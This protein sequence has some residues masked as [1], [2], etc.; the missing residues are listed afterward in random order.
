MM[1]AK[2]Q[3]LRVPDT[4]NGLETWRRWAATALL[5][6]ASVAHL[7]AFPTTARAVQTLTAVAHWSL[8]VHE[9]LREL[10]SGDLDGDGQGEV[11]AVGRN[12]YLAALEADGKVIWETQLSEETYSACLADLD[13]DEAA[14]VLI[15]GPRGV[16]ALRGDGETLWFYRTGNPVD[17][18]AAADVQNDGHMEVLAATGYE[19]VYELSS[20]GQIIWHYWPQRR[21][22]G[23]T[24]RG[25]AIA[26]YDEDGRK[27]VAIAFD[28]PGYKDLPPSGHI[29]L[30][31]HD[32]KELWLR[33]L[34]TAALSIS[35]IDPDGWGRY[36]IAVG[37]EAGEF[38]TLYGDNSMRWYHELGSPVIC[39]IT[40]DLD[41]DQ[42]EEVVAVA[43]H[44]LLAL[45]DDGSLRWERDTSQQCVDAALGGSEGSV[46]RP[47]AVLSQISGQRKSAVELI[48]VRGGIEESYILPSLATHVH[49]SDLNAD[50]WAELLVQAGESVQLL[51]RA[52][53]V[54]HSRLSWRFKLD[55]EVTALDCS[56]VDADGRMEILAGAQDQNLYVLKDDASLAW[57]YTAPGVIRTV[58]TG[59]VDADG[60]REVIVGYNKFDQR[61][62]QQ[63]W[64]LS[65]LRGDGRVLWQYQMDNWLWSV[66][67]ADLNGDGKDEVLVGTGSNRVLAI[68]G[69]HLLWSYPTYGS[70]VSLFAADLN[71]GGRAEVLAGSEDHRAYDILGNGIL[72]WSWNTGRNVPVVCAADLNSDSLS[73]VLI[74]SEQGVLYALRLDGVT[75]WQNDLHDTPLALYAGD[76]DNDRRMEIA[77]GTRGGE[78]YMLGGTGSTLWEYALQARLLSVY[79]GDVDGDRHAEIV[80]GSVDGVLYV[81]TAGGKLE[82]RHELG[83]AV[84]MLWVGDLDA[85]GL[86][87]ILAGTRDGQVVMYEHTPNRPPLIS[88]PSIGPAEAGYIYAVDVSDPEGDKVDV[89]L[90]VQDPFSGNWHSVGTKTAT[91]SGMLYWFVDPFPILA[92][93]RMAA[94]RLT[95]SD[96]LNTGTLGP[97]RG[98]RVPGIPWYAYAAVPLV[99]SVFAGSYLTWRRSPTRR[100]RALYQ[101]L[102]KDPQQ[103]MAAMSP[104][105][106]NGNAT[107]ETLIRLAQQAR[108]AGD[109]T[110][111]GLAE[112][113]LLLSNRPTM[114]LQV[115]AAA[116]SHGSEAETQ[117]SDAR[118]VLVQI[119]KLLADLLEANS[120]ARIAV[121][122]PKL[123]RVQ[124]LVRAYEQVESEALL[125]L[126]DVRPALGQL[127]H[128]TKLMRNSERAEAAEDKLD[129]LTQAFEALG[130][131]AALRGGPQADVLSLIAQSWQRVITTL[132]EEWLG[133]AQLRCRLR[134][135]RIVA[136]REAVLMLE[137]QNKG[138]SPAVQTSVELGHA[139]NYQD[140]SG[141]VTLG[142]LM[143]G[144]MREASLRLMPP[145]EDQFRAEFVLR[146]D[147][148]E[149]QGKSQVF[150]DMVEVLAPSE[151]RIIPNP[152]VPGRPLEPASPMFYG[153]EEVFDFIAQNARGLL[154]RNILILIGQR[155]TG[156]TSMLLQLPFHLDDQYVVVYL[157]CQSLGLTPGLPSW[158]YDVATIIGET[159]VERGVHVATPTLEALE[160]QPARVFERDYLAQVQDALGDRT[161]L[162]LMDEF[163][164]L[165]M[166]VRAGRLDPTVFSYLRHLMQHTQRV[167]FAFVGTHRL[168]EMTT[169]YWSVL[170]N[171]ALYRH[172][173]YLDENSA[174]RLIIEPVQPYNM[175]YDDLAL[176]R[177]WQVTGGHPYFLQLL[178]YSLV[179]AHNRA[180]R[181]YTTVDDVDQALE[182]ILTL[183]SAHFSFLWETS[184]AR[185]RATLAVLTRLLSRLGQ[186]TWP[187][188]GATASDVAVLLA[189]HNLTLD[190]REVS[191]ALHSL[192]AR[193][194]LQEIPGDV[195]RYVFKVG[196]VA[197][198][199]E[200][201]KSL[202]SVIEELS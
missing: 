115:V 49:L 46:G 65:V 130:P 116:L 131:L 178:C 190:P 98:P 24:V 9:S 133:R 67:V 6:L 137:V 17:A 183:G 197:L 85:D 10:L 74:A 64:G 166:R 59:D 55:A 8:P 123:Q 76:W 37:T 80:A 120:V 145:N 13:N 151:F 165:E 161:L 92:A 35:A 83:D 90:E 174:R 113:Y 117:D 14:D 162:L 101:C 28:F 62:D 4:S 18:V 109:Q 11:V 125:P 148:R 52:R 19:H 84:S 149:A 146:Y 150:A 158:L 54:A 86:A 77:T 27:E 180:G 53:G 102:S 30:L 57:R 179:N 103:V 16:T 153:R 81:V 31:D 195:E 127:L 93:S 196:L 167:A 66:Q 23:G 91:R 88:N 189:E 201:F 71:G 75:F 105:A 141:G 136:G 202:Q 194:I 22:F 191:A 95:Y 186:A 119:Y 96:G 39:V 159:L 56:D 51:S 7:L 177:M 43:E 32:G 176:H 200:R 48:D 122:S 169:D 21:G 171:I 73:E 143:P 72:R 38:M 47:V 155:R 170:F 61:G 114:G 138:R 87:E 68:A 135:R 112:G 34:Q 142:T 79:P 82:G 111:A 193:E 58:N 144:H 63:G 12:G 36:L 100:A 94:Y 69:G 181:S 126:P 29:R 164:E 40:G 42:Q 104:L 132:R 15:A 188:L 198:W 45:E 139:G 107:T 185:E 110:V 5:L 3:A 108:A 26:D 121:L 187:K 184:S 78:L 199:I 182:E 134:T 160:Q 173:G 118:G 44:H 33:N 129:Y 89:S 172:V 128:V 124:R 106:L 41:G 20:T 60:Q 1:R 152:Y 70:V 175:A 154:Q 147:D 99:L 140:L 157:D 168:E 97:L 2:G 192:T 163:E 50:G 25:L 156:K